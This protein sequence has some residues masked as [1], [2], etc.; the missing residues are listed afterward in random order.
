MLPD[1][2]IDQPTGASPAAHPRTVVE[3]ARELGISPFTVRAWIQHRRIG[4]LR[5]GRS[6]RIP[7]SEIQRLLRVGFVP[8]KQLETRQ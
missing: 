1:T 4:F 3:A 6:V 2:V 5:L 8:A 7:E